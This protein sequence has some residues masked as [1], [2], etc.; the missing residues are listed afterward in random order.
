MLFTEGRG[1]GSVDRFLIIG[2]A[3]KRRRRGTRN[4]WPGMMMVVLALA[5][6]VGGKNDVRS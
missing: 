4:V 5:G 6:E 3:E 2:R 1:G